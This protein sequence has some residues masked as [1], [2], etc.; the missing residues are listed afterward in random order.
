MEALHRQV[1]PFLLRRMKEDVL[2]DLPPKI[3]QDYYCNLSPLQVYGCAMGNSRAMSQM[4]NPNL[5]G[6]QRHNRNLCSSLI[7][8]FITCRSSYM[9]T[10]LS[11]E[12]RPVWR[13]AS[14][15]PQQK[16][17]RNL[18]SRPQ[19]MSSRYSFS[20]CSFYSQIITIN[21]SSQI[22]ST[23]SCI[24]LDFCVIPGPAVPEEAVQPSELGLDF[25][26]SRV[27]THH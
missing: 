1:L 19:V 16:K 2:Q 11:P 8:C 4:R 15:Q 18:N 23:C 24:H 27:Q 26:A 3:I 10:L 14:Q 6:L 17:R 12:P 22:I 5:E 9:K 20:F 25:T 13:T 7:C 21:R